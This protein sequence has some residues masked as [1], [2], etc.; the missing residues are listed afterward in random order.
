MDC[1]RTSSN[2]CRTILGFKHYV[3]LAK[4]KSELTKIM[5]SFEG[6]NMQE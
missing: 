6:K 2:K 4:E 1:R 3:I 5:S